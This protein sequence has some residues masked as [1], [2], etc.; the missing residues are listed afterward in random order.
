MYDAFSKIDIHVEITIPG[1][2]KLFGINSNEELI[3]IDEYIWEKAYFSSILR[4]MVQEKA[5]CTKIY[6]EFKTIE[7]MD[8]FLEELLEFV[9]KNNLPIENK[10]LIAYK[11]NMILNIVCNYLIQKRRYH[12]AIDFFKKVVGINF[13]Y[14]VFLSE[15]FNSL[16]NHLDT[17]KLIAPIL[18]KNPHIT[19][20]I[21]QEAVSI[22]EIKRFDLA[23]RLTRYLLQISPECFE[24]WLLYL[25]ILIR[26]KV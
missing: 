3:N 5:P 6:P 9:T 7:D 20:L 1:G 16:G 26:C 15:I 11:G 25:E 19:T 23:G 17:I 24:I 14:I 13:K 12:Y 18:Q 22:M 10:D 4:A 2:M 8:F 21:Y